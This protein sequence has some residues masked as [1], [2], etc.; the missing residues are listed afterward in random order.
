MWINKRDYEELVDRIGKHEQRL[1]SV[2]AQ[3]DIVQQKLDD[4]LIDTRSFDLTP[5]GS[6]Y[7]KYIKE[8]TIRGEV[9]AIIKYLGL[10]IKATKLQEPKVSVAKKPV[11]TAAKTRRK[12]AKTGKNARS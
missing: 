5:S 7:F 2:T 12:P 10:E 6:P 4:E 8:P 11:T 9:K 1:D 3:L